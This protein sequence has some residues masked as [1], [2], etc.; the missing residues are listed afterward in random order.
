MSSF[1]CAS[2][3]MEHDYCMR[4]RAN[5]VPGRPSCVLSKNSVFAVP[6]EQ[7]H[8]REGRSQGARARQTDLMALASFPTVI[9]CAEAVP[10][11]CHRQLIADALVAHGWDVRHILGSEKN[12]TTPFDGVCSGCSGARDLPWPDV[13]L[14]A[15]PRHCQNMSCKMIE[16]ARQH[17][18]STLVK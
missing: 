7:A 5:C 6:V 14:T 13:V 3:D 2:F 8:P 4:L 11:R 18:R 9:L 15:A 1:S 16:V 17:L 10:W 12:T